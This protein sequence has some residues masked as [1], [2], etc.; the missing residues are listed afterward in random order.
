MVLC[1]LLHVRAVGFDGHSERSDAV[2]RHVHQRGEHLVITA[3]RMDRMLQ[4]ADPTEPADV[5]SLRAFRDAQPRAVRAE[6]GCLA[7]WKDGTDPCTAPWRGVLCGGARLAALGFEPSGQPGALS[8]CGLAAIPVGFHAAALHYLDLSQ[9]R[10]L[11]VPNKTLS[12]LTRLE[13]LD[14]SGNRLRSVPDAVCSLHLSELYIDSN[15]LEALPECI[16]TLSQLTTL[17]ARDNWIQTVPSGVGQLVMLTS[18]SLEYNGLR[19]LPPSI[20][21]LT[22]LTELFLRSNQ[23]QALPD[24]MGRLE[25]LHYLGLEDNQLTA[26]PAS[27]GSGLRSLTQL[28]LDGNLMPALPEWLCKSHTFGALWQLQAQEMGI[29]S[30]SSSI[31]NCVALQELVL[32]GNRLLRLPKEI[33]RLTRLTLLRVSNNNLQY[34]PDSV[35]QLLRLR[36]L[37]V[38]GNGLRELPFTLNRLSTLRTLAVANNKLRILPSG[39]GSCTGLRTLRADHN[40]LTSLPPDLALPGLGTL[41]LN[42][43]AILSL[44][45]SIGY[46]LPNLTSLA[47]GDN[48]L[49]SLPDSMGSMKLLQYLRAESNALRA[50]PAWV[51]SSNM[52]LRLLDASNNSIE[53][54]PDQLSNQSLSH[55]NLQY[56]QLQSTTAAVR[57][58]AQYGYFSSFQIS[59]KDAH[60]GSLGT[61]SEFTGVPYISSGFIRSDECRVFD[62]AEHPACVPKLVTLP[63]HCRVGEPCT[64]QIGFFDRDAF[65]IRTGGMTNMTVQRAG[66]AGNRDSSLHAPLVYDRDGLYVATIPADPTWVNRSG[67]HQFSLF[68][69]PREFY[70]PQDFDGVKLCDAASRSPYPSCVLTLRYG[71]RAC[72]PSS[73]TAPDVTG[74][75]CQCLPGFGSDTRVMATAVTPVCILS[76]PEGKIALPET[77]ECVCPPGTFSANQWL[78]C[79]DDEYFERTPTQTG[80]LCTGCPKCALCDKSDDGK[81]LITLQQG[82]RLNASNSA[83][84]RELLQHVQ[85]TAVQFAFRCPYGHSCPQV[86]LATTNYSAYDCPEGHNGVLCEACRPGFSSRGNENR[87]CQPCALHDYSNEA[88]GINAYWAFAA[89]SLVVLVA[90]AIVHTQWVRL[91]KAKREF[92]TNFRILLGWAQVLSLLSG[93]LDLVFPHNSKPTMSIISLAVVDIGSLVHFECWGGDWYAKWTL[94]VGIMPTLAGCFVSLRFFRQWV[95]AQGGVLCCTGL[96]RSAENGADVIRSA[97]RDAISASSFLVMLLYPQIS[98]KIFSALCCRRL[99]PG[100]SVLEVDYAVNCLSDRYSNYQIVAAILAVMVPIGVPLGLGLLLYKQQRASWR[101]WQ[102]TLPDVPIEHLVPRTW[103]TLLREGPTPFTPGDWILYKAPPLAIAHPAT[104]MRDHDGRLVGRL[105]NQ[106]DG[107]WTVES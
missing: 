99:G 28:R 10:L 7:D 23:L 14:L 58:F 50:L 79:F 16:G 75:V 85:G 43:N 57:H 29:R 56:N 36:T 9:N 70:A 82:W 40:N 59:F 104:G 18:L 91:K 62:D 26:L 81:D 33:G 102:S 65:L 11:S 90:A 60:S 105:Q 107:V 74:A 55:V 68:V 53:S 44:P 80:S 63:K 19:E 39:L 67:D 3:G 6:G 78:E 27:L 24:S 87:V 103:K 8:R 48:R 88:F 5:A 92:F 73:N 95:S 45:P 31:G 17:N 64:F 4:A 2:A 72:P 34:L 76:C 22:N 42:S 13:Y 54:L 21:G 20:G 25:Q 37:L 30:L 35:G 47:L 83:E 12:G 51:G 49:T 1:Q 66:D 38:R 71:A 89:L 77:S 96:F 98:D 106:Q 41:R 69:G 101:R 15:G 46:M 61:V 84:L 97:K 52:Q 86:Q 100:L 32:D 93:V 94:V